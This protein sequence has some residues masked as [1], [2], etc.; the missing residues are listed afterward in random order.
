AAGYISGI[1]FNR[2]ELICAEINRLAIT[3]PHRCADAQ[4][5][6]RRDL[7]WHAAGSGDEI[8][9]TGRRS[10]ITVGGAGKSDPWTIM[11]PAGVVAG[12][13][14]NSDLRNVAARYGG[15]PDI[16]QSTVVCSRR[17]PRCVSETRAV[18]RPLRIADRELALRE[19]LFFFLIEIEN[20]QVCHF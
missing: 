18:R 1:D 11:R 2:F 20:P 17:G 7:F 3:R 6:F 14:L 5:E 10:G 15:H 12:R 8:E 4:I 13:G 16:A 19:A 9:I